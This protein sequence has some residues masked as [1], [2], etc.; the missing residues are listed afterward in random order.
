[1]LHIH[2]MV[3]M[4]ILR[5]CLIHL[6]ILM[7]TTI[8]ANLT[9]AALRNQT[10]YEVREINC[11]VQRV[12]HPSALER[13]WVDRIE[14]VAERTRQWESGCKL[15]RADEAQIRKLMEYHRT[16]QNAEEW[17]RVEGWR[18]E[19]ILSYFELTEICDGINRTMY[20]PIEPLIGF[21]RHP[22][23]HCLGGRNL[24]DKEYMFIL[25]R[26]FVFPTP[27]KQTNVS[28]NYYFDMGASTYKSGA[29]GAS[30]SWF[31]DSYKKRGIEFDRIL[32]WEVEKMD[33]EEI[34]REYPNDVVNKVSY[35]NLPADTSLEA[36]MSPVRMIKDLVRPQDF[37]MMKIDIDNDPVELAIIQ[38]FR[39]DCTVTDLIDEFFF[40]HHVSFHPVEYMGWTTSQ[41]LNN[42]TESYQLFSDLRHKGIRAHSWV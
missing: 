36:K 34:Y 39:N 19:G 21:L 31:V 5:K 26:D 41:K 7:L 2:N 17:G 29:G 13:K 1:M 37:L 4:N 18:E 40:E 22:L 14:S 16:W 3:S 32:A 23:F 24:V 35:F 10:F 20:V 12:Y 30:Q 8:S 25:H 28:T 38:S 6:V 33:P 15:M 27:K 42:I 11:A 9:F